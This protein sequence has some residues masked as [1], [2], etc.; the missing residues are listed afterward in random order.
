MIIIDELALDCTTC[1][2]TTTVK[3]NLSKPFY[4][5]LGNLYNIIIIQCLGNRAE[6]RLRE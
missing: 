1:K 2:N 5:Y 3:L 4:K 6:R